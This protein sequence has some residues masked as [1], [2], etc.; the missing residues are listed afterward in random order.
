MRL[1]DS[2]LDGITYFGRVVVV[3]YW[4]CECNFVLET[5]T[6]KF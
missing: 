4:T 1:G 6:V 2:D 3:F 5:A